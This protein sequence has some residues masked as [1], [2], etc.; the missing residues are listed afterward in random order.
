MSHERLASRGV[1]LGLAGMLLLQIA[2]LSLAVYAF[3]QTAELRR[4][5]TAANCVRSVQAEEFRA[6][7][8]LERSKASAAA[9]AARTAAAY[10]RMAAALE[11]V[12][13]RQGDVRCDR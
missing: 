5:D 2:C 13:E 11:D 4:F 8:E 10:E 3:G 9:D 1:L 7:A 12:V 6:L